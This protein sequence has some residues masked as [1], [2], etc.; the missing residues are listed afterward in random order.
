MASKKGLFLILSF[1][2]SRG[3]ACVICFCSAPHQSVQL[4]LS[5]IYRLPGP[6]LFSFVIPRSQFS[7]THSFLPAR[8]ALWLSNS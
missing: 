1:F 5:L 4:A 2:L 8:S 7:I 3:L 6:S